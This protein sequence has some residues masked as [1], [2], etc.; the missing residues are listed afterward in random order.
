MCKINCNLN[1]SKFTLIPRG[2]SVGLSYRL[3]ESMSAGSIPVIISDNNV[4]PFS[5][6]INYK[7]F[8]ISIKE[9]SIKNI[10][11]KLKNIK[12]INEIQNNLLIIYNIYF[13]SVE[14][15]ISTALLIFEMKQI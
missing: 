2:S 7:K 3:V 6:M 13:S 9:K 5:D 4:L 12:N 10:E 15:I 14:K 8:S 1:N 11:K